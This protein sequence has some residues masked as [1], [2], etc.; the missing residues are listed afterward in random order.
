MYTTFEEN[1]EFRALLRRYL[2]SEKEQELYEHFTDTP[3]Q[4][5]EG[6]DTIKDIFY[7]RP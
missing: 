4:Y 6:R 1:P 2:S 3:Y 5:D 7:T